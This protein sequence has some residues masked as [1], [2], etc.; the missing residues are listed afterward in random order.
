MIVHG[1]ENGQNNQKPQVQAS[2]SES[3]YTYKVS[4]DQEDSY[5]A[6]QMWYFYRT[7]L[8]LMYLQVT[9]AGKM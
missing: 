4:V 1:K 5:S 8:S 2:Q 6:F 7:W 3:N 9:Y